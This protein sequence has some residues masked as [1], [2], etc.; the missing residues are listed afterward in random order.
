[1]KSRERPKSRGGIGVTCYN[2]V[3]GYQPHVDVASLQLLEWYI[4]LGTQSYFMNA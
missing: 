2:G 1:M 3:E 4:E